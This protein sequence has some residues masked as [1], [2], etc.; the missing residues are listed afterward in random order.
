LSTPF[1]D[2]AALAGLGVRHPHA[3]RRVAQ[4]GVEVR[5]LLR[6]LERRLGDKAQAP[7]LEVGPELED[8]GHALE[9]LQVPLPEHD[10]AVLVLDLAAALVELAHEHQDGLQEVQRLEPGHHARL[11]VVFGHELV[12]AAAD[13]RRDVPRPYKRVQ[14]QV[15]RVEQRP[16]RRHDGDVVAEHGEVLDAL[17]LRPL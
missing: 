15:R 11:A 17:L 2:L 3:R 14:A 7:P 12:G 1:E 4:L 6:E 13:H 10:P 16:H 5:V 9:G 8:L